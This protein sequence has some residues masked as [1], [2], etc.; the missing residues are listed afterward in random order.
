MGSVFGAITTETPVFKLVADFPT[1]QIRL[2]D[3][4]VRIHH[5]Y[6]ATPE[7]S[8]NIGFRPLAECN[9]FEYNIVV[10]FGNNIS[11]ETGKSKTISMTAPVLRHHLANDQYK[12]EFVLPKDF[13]N[14][15]EVPKPNDER[16]VAEEIP[17]QVL[18]VTTFS[19]SWDDSELVSTKEK[20][21]RMDAEGQGFQLDPDPNH[22]VRAAYN[23]RKFFYNHF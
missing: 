6:K 10:I 2:Y 7:S 17:E 9:C 22:V 14:I 13:K 16:I 12:M 4:Q 1:F 11:N 18:A 21:L 20:Q 5:S 15:S 8:G 19:G 3:Q 23:P